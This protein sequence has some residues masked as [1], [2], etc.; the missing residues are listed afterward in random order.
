MLE[1]LTPDFRFASLTDIETE[2]LRQHHF[3]ALLL[4][5]DNTLLV[6]GENLLPAGH[7]L[8]LQEL[9]RA[10]V[11]VVLVSNNGGRRVEA[12]PSQLTAGGIPLPVL[13]WAGKPLKQAFARAA[14]RLKRP[15][16][17]GTGAPQGILVVGDQLF[18]DVLG[19]H[20]SG[21]PAA[22]T[23]PLPGRDFIFTRMVRL[24]ERWVAER[25]EKQGRMP[26][27]TGKRKRSEEIG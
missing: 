15:S 13:T 1:K 4:D 2:W 9:R 27:E 5:I 7:L 20:C 8:W 21:L 19:A 17:P 10:G 18:T 14:A 12:L 3:D 11:D 22:W 26:Q 23:R 16:V 6:R 25:L 24:A